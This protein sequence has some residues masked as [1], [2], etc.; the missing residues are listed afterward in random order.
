MTTRLNITL[1]DA[2][3]EKLRAASENKPSEY[4]ERAVIRQ[5]LADDLRKLAEWE[6]EHPED[7][8]WGRTNDE[9]AEAILFGSAG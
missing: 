2:V 4:I 5:M 7:P 6:R 3:A 8:G 1:P 9:T